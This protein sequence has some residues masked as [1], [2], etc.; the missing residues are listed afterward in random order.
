MVLEKIWFLAQ[1]EMRQV[2]EIDEDIIRKNLHRLKFYYGTADGWVPKKNFDN[3][4]KSF[5]GV[6]AELCTLQINHGFIISHGPTMARM[7]SEWIRKRV[8]LYS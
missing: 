7:L 6:D 2:G 4:I 5:P 1:D 8:K 3:L